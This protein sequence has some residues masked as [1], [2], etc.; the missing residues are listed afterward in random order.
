M[1]KG[2]VACPSIAGPVVYFEL[3][4]RTLP[5]KVYDTP[6]IR[7]VALIGH[8]DSGKTSLAS[9]MLFLS[10][11]V[12]RLGKVEEGTTITDFDDEEIERKISLQTA[13]APLEWRGGG[14]GG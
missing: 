2:S 1:E 11:A 14:G 4:E 7:N 6:D 12:N 10:G 3:S 8:G 13:L 9:A 5:M